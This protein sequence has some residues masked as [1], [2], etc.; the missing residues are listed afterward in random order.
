MIQLPCD[1]PELWEPKPP[2]LEERC[3][4]EESPNDDDGEDTVEREGDE[5]LR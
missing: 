4:G 5:A 2:R 3:D 1:D